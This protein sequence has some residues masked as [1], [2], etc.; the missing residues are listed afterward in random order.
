MYHRLQLVSVNEKYP[1]GRFTCS[2]CGWLTEIVSGI[3]R[4][5]VLWVLSQTEIEIWSDWR[6]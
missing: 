3:G 2:S 5:S 1:D 6:K 4:Q